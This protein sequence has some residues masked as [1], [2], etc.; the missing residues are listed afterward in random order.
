MP[1]EPTRVQRI[2]HRGKAAIS[3]HL[4]MLKSAG[5]NAKVLYYE[6]FYD[7]LLDRGQRSTLVKDLLS[8]LGLRS[9]GD[10]MLDTI[11][12]YLDPDRYRFATPETYRAIPDID[13]V[14]REVGSDEN[15]WLFR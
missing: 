10:D 7:P 3:S 14:E 12:N 1:L 8:F 6:E 9:I 2:V 4:E 11:L 15:G 13:R 5:A